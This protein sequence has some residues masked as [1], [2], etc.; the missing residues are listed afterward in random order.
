[1]KFA[2]WVFLFM[3][4]ISTLGQDSTAQGMVVFHFYAD[5]CPECVDAMMWLENNAIESDTI[6]HINVDAN[7]EMAK[8]M[9]VDKL[10]Y[11]MFFHNGILMDI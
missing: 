9:G 11:V 5:Y 4:S 2:V 10:P 6:Y 1:V 7:Y 8:R 3:L